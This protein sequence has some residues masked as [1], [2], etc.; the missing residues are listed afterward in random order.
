MLS[1]LGI[2]I[3]PLNRIVQNSAAHSNLWIGDAY[4]IGVVALVFGV[5]S[6][7]YKLIEKPWQEYARRKPSS[8]VSA[9]AASSRA[10]S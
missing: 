10:V 7:T 3:A 9:R 4:V 8:L 1:I 2:L 6:I 5:S